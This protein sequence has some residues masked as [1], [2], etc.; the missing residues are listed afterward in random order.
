MSARRLRLIGGLVLVT[1]VAFACVFYLKFAR[2]GPTIDDLMPG[3]SE[4]KARQNAI[5]MGDM[6]VTLLGWMDAL[7]DPGAEAAIIAGASVVVAGIC[8]W[9]ASLLDAPDSH[10]RPTGASE[11]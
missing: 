5:L 7:K 2:S 11:K 8:F 9:V 6:V 1:G 10:Q 4:Q 3:Y